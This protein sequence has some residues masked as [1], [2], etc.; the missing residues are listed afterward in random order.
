[1]LSR[2]W[3]VAGL[4]ADNLGMGARRVEIGRA[5]EFTLQL[6]NWSGLTPFELSLPFSTVG[7][8]DSDPLKRNDSDP[9]NHP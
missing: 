9:L 2:D 5:A 6:A 3:G 8:N 1:M 7:F 4:V